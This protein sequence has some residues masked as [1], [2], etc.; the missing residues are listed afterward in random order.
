MCSR[1][2]YIKTKQHKERCG[3]DCFYKCYIQHLAD[4]QS[5]CEGL[6]LLLTLPNVEN[7]LRNACKVKHHAPSAPRNVSGNNSHFDIAHSFARCSFVSRKCQVIVQAQRSLHQPSMLDYE[8]QL[9]CSTNDYLLS[10]H[11]TYGHAPYT[12]TTEHRQVPA[13]G[14]ASTFGRKSYIYAARP[15]PIGSAIK[16]SLSNWRGS[17]TNRAY[18]ISSRATEQIVV[19]TDDTALEC[20]GVDFPDLR[21]SSSSNRVST[22]PFD[23]LTIDISRS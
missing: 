14:V 10:Q 13:T 2:F 18:S 16:P 4:A 19:A 6:R 15:V 5:Q 22:K 3:F 9:L 21:L 8:C 23:V 20:C 1:L 7:I 12:K 17:A 11:P